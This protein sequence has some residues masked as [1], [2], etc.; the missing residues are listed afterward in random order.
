MLSEVAQQSMLMTYDIGSGGVSEA[1]RVGYD[2]LKHP[3]QYCPLA[4]VY[5]IGVKL[6]GCQENT[7]T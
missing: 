4:F 6:V 3:D 1:R 7:L 5:L 2:G